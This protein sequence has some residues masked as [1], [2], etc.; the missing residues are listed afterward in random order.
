MQPMQLQ[1]TRDD[2]TNLLATTRQV[3]LPPYP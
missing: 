1:R 2:L 3:W